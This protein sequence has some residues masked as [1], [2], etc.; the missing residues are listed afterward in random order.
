[1]ASKRDEQSDNW[2]IQCKG[3]E[4]F[5]LSRRREMMRLIAG[6]VVSSGIP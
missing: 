5:W 1:M 2:C 6:A 3:C 4:R